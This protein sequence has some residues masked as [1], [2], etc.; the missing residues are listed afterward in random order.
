[1]E[2]FEQVGPCLLTDK[3]TKNR[4]GAALLFLSDYEWESVS[5]IRWIIMGDE[6]YIHYCTP[7]RKQIA[8][9]EP[10]EPAPKKAKMTRS[11]SKIMTIIF[12][13]WKS[14]LLLEYHPVS[15][16]ITEDTYEKMLK[17]LQA[18]VCH[19]CPTQRVYCLSAWQCKGAK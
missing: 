1:M 14:I 16:S 12:W 19:K 15:I 3:H 13:D 2:T 7:I 5:L 10:S 6:T 18:A 4:M 11:T 9:W 8:W 17:A